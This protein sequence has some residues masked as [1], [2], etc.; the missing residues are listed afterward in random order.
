M[1]SKPLVL[2]LAAGSIAGFAQTRADGLV[3]NSRPAVSLP[4]PTL[5]PETRGDIYMARNLFRE[6]IDMFRSTASPNDPVI[7]NK[8]GISFHQMQLL[9]EARKCYERALKRK[10]D[11]V[12]A[13]NNIGTIYYSKKS[14]R[15]AIS[16]YRKALKVM[17]EDPKSSSIYMNLGTAL[18]AR[19][20]YED[21]TVAYQHALRLDPEVFERHGNFGVMLQERSIEDRAKY[22]FYLAKLYAKNKRPELALQYLRKAV[23]EGFKE[24]KRL[25]E[26]PEFAEMQELPEFKELI[27]LQPR[28]L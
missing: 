11:Y 1:Y 2:L 16:W 12:E 13:M 23:E 15:R 6:A 26:E 3:E 9:D 28:V 14:H 18:F 25:V 10:P 7:L 21:A 24:K 27:A 20:K 8:M 4:N 22:H 19:K 17:P 5:S